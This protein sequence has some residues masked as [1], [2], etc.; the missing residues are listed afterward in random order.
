MFVLSNSR[1]LFESG[2]IH[3]FAWSTCRLTTITDSSSISYCSTMGLGCQSRRFNCLFW[4]ETRQR[5]LGHE[6]SPYPEVVR[7]GERELTT[8]P[9]ERQGPERDSWQLD[10]RE[11]SWW[12]ESRE[13]GS[14][15]QL[16]LDKREANREVGVDPRRGSQHQT[17]EQRGEETR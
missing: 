2:P 10:R 11:E 6:I 8:Q 16:R 14:R 3:F 1:T 4:R 7:G 15:R 17:P 12:L 5:I 13:A 9:R